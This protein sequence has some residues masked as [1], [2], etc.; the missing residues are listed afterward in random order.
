[1]FRFAQQDT[2]RQSPPRETFVLLTAPHKYSEI[3]LTQLGTSMRPVVNVLVSLE[4]Q[5]VRSVLLSALQPYP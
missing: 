3:W 4:W 2:P 1:M 5:Q